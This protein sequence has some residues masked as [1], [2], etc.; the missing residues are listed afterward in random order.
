MA[1]KSEAEQMEK[2]AKINNEQD[3]IEENHKNIEIL[4]ENRKRMKDEARGHWEAELQR[5]RDLNALKP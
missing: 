4:K 1:Q 2:E 5:S 3:A